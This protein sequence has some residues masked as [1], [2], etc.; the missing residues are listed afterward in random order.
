MTYIYTTMLTSPHGAVH[1]QQHVSIFVTTNMSSRRT[2]H[3][4]VEH[5]HTII[6]RRVERAH[7]ARGIAVARISVVGVC[8]R[9][10]EYHVVVLL[11]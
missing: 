11:C 3:N 4:R 9:A 10:C 7:A 5:A 6:A 2:L 8:A 1:V